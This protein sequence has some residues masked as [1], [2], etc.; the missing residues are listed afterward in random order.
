MINR[1]ELIQESTSLGS[2]IKMNAYTSNRKIH[3]AKLKWETFPEGD[4]V[5][6][7]LFNSFF[8]HAR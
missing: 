7:L 2:R 5:Q 3:F 1:T 4:A 8:M 6:T